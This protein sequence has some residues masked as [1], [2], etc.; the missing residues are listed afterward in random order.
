M[1]STELTKKRGQR[2]VFGEVECILR[3]PIHI[4]GM[5]EETDAS[6]QTNSSTHRPIVGIMK[7]KR[8]PRHTTSFK[9]YIRRVARSLPATKKLTI[10]SEVMSELDEL[11]HIVMHGLSARAYQVSQRLHQKTM[12]AKHIEGAVASIVTVDAG[13]FSEAKSFADRAM[14]KMNLN[15]RRRRKY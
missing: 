13:V 15:Q 11:M 14:A 8:K 5:V 2:V 12:T 3:Y 6:A 7:A 1:K 4:G 9:S 10:S